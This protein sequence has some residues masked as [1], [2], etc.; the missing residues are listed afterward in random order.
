MAVRRIAIVV[1]GLAT[2]GGVPA[3]AAF[4]YRAL[5]NSSS[6]EPHLI[7]LPMSPR[8][9]SSVRFLAPTSWLQGPEVKESTWNGWPY[10][11]V[12]AVGAEFEFQRYQPRRQLTEILSDY[13]LI[14][15]VA[16]APAWAYP[17]REITKPVCLQVATLI[18]VERE[19]FMREASGGRRLLSSAMN[20]I[21][22]RFEDKALEHLETVFVENQWM[23]DHLCQRLGPSRVV[24]APPGVDTEQFSPG[25]Y[26]PESYI[27][28][29]GRLGDPR[30]NISLLFRAYHRLRQLLPSA[31]Q[32]ILAGKTMPD[33]TT[34]QLAESLGIAEH[35]KT[36]KDVDAQQLVGLYRNASVFVLSSD[37]EGL[38]IVILEAM[39]SGLPVV[40]TRCGGPETAVKDGETGFLVP[41]DDPDALAGRMEQLLRDPVHA[42]HLGQAGRRRAEQ[43]F[44]IAAAARKFLERYDELLS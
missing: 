30:K 4:L 3:V 37:E 15:V 40:A 2:S 24:F 10:R 20:R 23:Y 33:S 44:S 32:L 11:H 9:N 35:I 6:Y 18:Q 39:A 1:P 34:W 26:C 5:L 36:F 16:G 38:G 12:G 31:P 42:E 8:D 14:Q 28:A 27:L 41:K 17:T 43:E 22:N 25:Q 19:A 29:V 7:S 13:D 21:V